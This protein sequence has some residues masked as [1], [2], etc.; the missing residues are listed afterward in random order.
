LSLN[1]NNKDLLASYNKQTN[2]Y[3]PITNQESRFFDS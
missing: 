2:A 3:N 1:K